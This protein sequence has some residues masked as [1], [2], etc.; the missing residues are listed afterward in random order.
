MAKTT[1]DFEQDFLASLTEKT[2]HDLSTW[3]G[4]I[5]SVG[6]TKIMETIKW[7]KTEHGLNHMQATFL[8]NI[9]QNDGKPVYSDADGLTDALF[10]G[11]EQWRPVYDA[12]HDAIEQ[13]ISGVKFIP[14][15][16]YM[17]IAGKRE[18]AV[19]RM[20][21]KELRVGM[22]LGKRPFTQIVQKGKGLGAMP[23]ISHMIV[24]T[25]N[26]GV[27]DELLAYL[28]QAHDHVHG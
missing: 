23:R 27:N 20:M 28:Q 17:S 21:K 9:F 5:E 16:T 3:M 12:L 25:G 11:K 4:M 26:D 14:K 15:K 6:L 24:V 2:G 1:H 8:A 7:I 10:K 13:R 22:D 19:A 18:F